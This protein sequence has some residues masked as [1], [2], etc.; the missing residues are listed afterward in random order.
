MDET[1]KLT[2]LPREERAQGET[3][4]K[5]RE[6]VRWFETNDAERVAGYAESFPKSDRMN[7]VRRVLNLPTRKK[8]DATR[9]SFS[10]QKTSMIW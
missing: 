10:R 4:E 6:R 5:L 1:F 8:R 3:L 7:S 9:S 2:E